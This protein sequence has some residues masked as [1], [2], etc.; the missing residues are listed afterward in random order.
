MGIV[1][2]G[3]YEIEREI[4]SGGGG[5]VYLGRHL[6]LNKAV[7]LKADKRTLRA[8]PEALRREVNALKDLSHTYIPQVY[9]FV[10]EDGVVYTVM[11][12]I[13]GE[14]LDK[15]LGRGEH[16][17]QAQVV[18]WAKQLLEALSYLHNRPPYGILHGDIKP[19][20]IMVT[21]RG[22]IRLIDFNIALALGEEGAVQVGFSR[23]YASPEHYGIDYRDE[24]GS[25]T[26]DDETR[27]EATSKTVLPG[28]SSQSQPNRLVK[29]DVRSDIYSLGATL[30]H[31]LG[32]VK[33]PQDAKE[34]EPLDPQKVSYA[35]ARVIGKA[36]APDPNKRYQ[37]AEEM[38]WDFRHLHQN[39]PRTKKLK[40]TRNIAA[41][42]LAGSCLLGVGLSFAG[43]RQMEAEQARIAQ[44][45]QAA[46]A[47]L[48]ALREAEN[49]YGQ[50]NMPKAQALA[51]NA[52]RDGSPYYAQAQRVLTDALGVYD[53][54]DGLK[55]HCVVELPSEVLK[56]RISPAGTWAAALYA[57][58][59]AVF[60]T[61]TGEVLAELPTRS[62]ALSELTFLGEDTLIYAGEDGLTAYD[63]STGSSRWQ[64]GAA[65]RL[66]LSG[67]GNRVVSIPEGASQA[68]VYTT[69]DGQLVQS[70]SLGGRRQSVPADGGILADPQDALLALNDDG[71]M[72]AISLEGGG[73]S[74]YDVAS[75]EEYTILDH[76]DYYHF[77][78]GFYQN[79]FAFSAW[80]EKECI[81]LIYDARTL[82]QNGGFTAQVPFRVQAD[83]TGI[84]VASGNLLVA[85]DPITG[86][87]R[88]LAYA[89]A[90]IASYYRGQDGSVVVSTEQGEYALFNRAAQLISSGSRPSGCEFLAMAGPY[91]A[92]AS[93]ET[94]D[95][96]VLKLES[97]PSAQLCAYPAELPHTEARVSMDGERIM[98]FQYDGFAILDRQGTQLCRVDIPDAAEV[99]DQQFRRDEKDSRLEVTYRDG[100]VRAYSAQDGS[101]LWEKEGPAPAGDLAETFETSCWWFE[102]SPHDAPKVYEKETGELYRELE[103]ES[104]LTYVTETGDYLVAQYLSAQGERYGLLLDQNCD[105]LAY[106]PGLCDVVGET[107]VFDD[108]HGNLRQSRIYSPQEL[109]ALAEP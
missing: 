104:Y 87:Q 3:T 50:G 54:F 72:M 77:E 76:S 33:P 45:E 27:L 20:N 8:K 29:L 18:A 5:T 58:Q 48:S 36:M 47:A 82:T 61:E 13:E 91:V 44:E 108:D 78:G 62:S 51:L 41:A 94:P 28:E 59:V 101:V 23:G 92:L 34:V 67:D 37:T 97:H 25:M 68:D 84:Y 17:S 74:L 79:Y 24:A 103:Q 53:L 2:A 95:V 102:T 22:D 60:D 43:L 66:A 56:L 55:A 71:S 98:L 93:R 30:Y 35:V 52:M 90:D 100:R 21:P 9:D 42:V 99:Y 75:G 1:I 64:G 12:Y 49:A 40:R 88:E 14:S 106:L 89:S 69:V 16:F 39:D 65:T 32:G 6:R 4:G 57:Y 80:S 31:L 96:Q 38:L 63:L 7:V 73:L 10:V 46:K 19:A 26:L 85:V 70:V 86:E 109:R 15:P 81:F 105:A 83:E 107:L 11:D